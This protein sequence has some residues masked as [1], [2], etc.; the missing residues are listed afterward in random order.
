MKHQLDLIKAER[1]GRQLGW[2]SVEWKESDGRDSVEQ[3]EVEGVSFGR[4]VY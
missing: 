4:M 2:K 3:E 1:D